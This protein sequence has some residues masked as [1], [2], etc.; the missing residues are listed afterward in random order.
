MW[1]DKL[2][3][4][5]GLGWEVLQEEEGFV[6]SV[7]SEGWPD[8]VGRGFTPLAALIGLVGELARELGTARSAEASLVELVTGVKAAVQSDEPIPEPYW[9]IAPRW[10]Q[11][12]AIDANGVRSWYERE[13]A[14]HESDGYWMTSFG[15]TMGFDQEAPAYPRWRETLRKRPAEPVN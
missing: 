6:V 9:N 14:L 2:G 12:Y 11:W 8:V 13:P 7:W 5:D 4:S 15:K 3:L 10:A 1:S